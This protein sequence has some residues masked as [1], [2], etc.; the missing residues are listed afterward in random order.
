MVRSLRSVT[1]NDTWVFTKCPSLLEDQ[2]E[3]NDDQ[4]EAFK[5]AQIDPWNS[6]PWLTYLPVPLQGSTFSGHSTKT[7]LGN[8][9]RSLMYCLWYS[10]KAGVGSTLND[11]RSR[12]VH[13]Q[14]AGDDCAIFADKSTCE[15]I[16][17]S[18]LLNSVSDKT[19]EDRIG[20]G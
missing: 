14:V 6:K 15:K 10:H 16:A 19:S 2:D 5:L 9:L 20:L 13:I 3:W 1:H 7:T 18:V 12:G 17:A 4:K 8:T 11:L